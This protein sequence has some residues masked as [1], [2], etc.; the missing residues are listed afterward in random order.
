M[1]RRIGSAALRLHRYSF[2][3]LLVDG[4]L[5]A[6][7]WY[8]AF[9]LRFPD[10][11]QRYEDLLLFALPGVVIITLAILFLSGAYAKRWSLLGQ[12]DYEGLLRGIVIA[13]LVTVGVIAL[14]AERAGVHEVR[15]SVPFGVAAIYFLPLFVF[16][17]AAQAAVRAVTERPLR[18]FRADKEARDVLIVGAGNGGQLVVREILRN[19]GLR[20]R[21]V[22]F[23]DD[24]PAKAGLKIEAG[25]KVLGSTNE[26]P[27]VLEDPARGGHH[28]D[29]LGPGHA[30]R[31]H[32]LPSRAIPVRTLR[33]TFELLQTGGQMVRQARE[34]RVEDVL[35]REPCA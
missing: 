2:P 32:G 1:R 15:V 8:L 16:T 22:G 35:G 29:P 9:A 25:L 7:A 14:L 28:R 6:L 18:G 17:G 24:D 19:P 10:I 13:V 4:V 31:R 33:A 21:P 23:V 34:V 27:R 3:Q 12:R 11:R 20:F 26:L 30:A 5:V